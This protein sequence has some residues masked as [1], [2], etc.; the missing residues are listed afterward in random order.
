LL[1]SIYSPY[2]LVLKI[3]NSSNVEHLLERNNWNRLTLTATSMQHLK[4]GV[5]KISIICCLG[6]LRILDV[7]IVVKMWELFTIKKYL[8]FVE[9]WTRN[10]FWKKGFFS[11]MLKHKCHM[12]K[13]LRG[14]FFMAH[15][16]DFNA[17]IPYHLLLFIWIWIDIKAEM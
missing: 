5:N 15:P 16:S 1:S 2:S 9:C 10:L 14:S 13:M 17:W 3:V 7:S 12:R 11:S 8:H 6:K 4:F